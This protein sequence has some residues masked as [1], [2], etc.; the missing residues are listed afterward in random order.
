M[1]ISSRDSPSFRAVSASVAH[2]HDAALATRNLKDFQGHRDPR[3][4]PMAGSLIAMEL[5]S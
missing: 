5:E 3:D 4:R 2:T 1:A